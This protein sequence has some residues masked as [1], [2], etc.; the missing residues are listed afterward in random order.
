MGWLI[1]EWVG[2]EGLLPVGVGT[3]RGGSGGGVNC[4]NWPDARGLR[5]LMGIWV[6]V[7]GLRIGVEGLLG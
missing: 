3:G 7:E 1:G 6:G 5:W 2:V 4:G